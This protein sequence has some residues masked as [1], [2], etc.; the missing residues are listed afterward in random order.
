MKSEDETI[1][2]SD[3]AGDALCRGGDVEGV[4]MSG[5]GV[6]RGV[7]DRKGRGSDGGSIG[8]GVCTTG[9]GRTEL[10][11]KLCEGGAICGEVLGRRGCISGVITTAGGDGGRD[12][13]M[14]DEPNGLGGAKR[15]LYWRGAAD[16]DTGACSRG[17]KAD[18]TSLS[19]SWD[20]GC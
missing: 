18:R 15:T 4:N 17:W 14:S 1:D 12:N 9:E 10:R 13:V 3:K 8:E 2:E 5:D 6:A 20:R 7:R 11:L 19:G 16:A